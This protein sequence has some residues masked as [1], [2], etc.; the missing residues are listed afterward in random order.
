[1]IEETSI[2]E[3][4]LKLRLSFG[5]FDIAVPVWNNYHHWHKEVLNLNFDIE[6]LETSIL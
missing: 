1:M 5:S 2:S 6:E 4:N 3:S